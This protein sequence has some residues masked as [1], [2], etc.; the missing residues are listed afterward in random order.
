MRDTVPEQHRQGDLGVWVHWGLTWRGDRV[1]EHRGA[2]TAVALGLC[3]GGDT[4]DT[5]LGTAGQRR[6][7]G[8]WRGAEGTVQCHHAALSPQLGRGVEEHRE[9]PG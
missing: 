5:V 9:H 8:S 1:L 6:A 4:G 3:W 2:G 7:G